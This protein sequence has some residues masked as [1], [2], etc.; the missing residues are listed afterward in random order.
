[1]LAKDLKLT[2]RDNIKEVIEKGAEIRSPYFVIKLLPAD[3]GP[4]KFAIVV[5]ARISKKA[6]ERNRLRRRIYEIIRLNLKKFSP[7]QAQKTVI[8]TKVRAL[9]ASYKTLENEL[10]KIL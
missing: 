6:V 8:L 9:N 4:T 3:S 10:I 2:R 5:S 7:A 1:M